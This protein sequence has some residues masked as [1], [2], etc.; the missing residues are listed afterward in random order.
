MDGDVKGERPTGIDLI[1]NAPWGT[2]F[3]QFYAGKQDLTEILVPYFKAGLES[4][5]FCMWVTA[6]SLKVEEAWQAL[7]QAMPNLDFYRQ[8][9]RIEII[10][11]TEWYLVDGHFDQQRILQGWV[12]KLEA[13][14]ARGCAGLRLSGDTFWL[15]KPDWKGFAEYEAAIDRVIGKYRILALCTYALERCGAAEVADVVKNHQ[16]ALL[17]RDGACR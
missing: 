2:H 12:R 16:F 9:G 10:P 3:C 5:E 17:K 14:L 15:E 6:P 1:G 11:Y 8:R 7:G 4:Q 13:A